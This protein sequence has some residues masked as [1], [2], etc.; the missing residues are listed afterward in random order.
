MR[1]ATA[2]LRRV[3]ARWQSGSA[4]SA[5]D[6]FSDDGDTLIEVLLSIVVLGIAVA[7]L[8]GFATAITSSANTVT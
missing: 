7:L 5:R 4:P 1:R 3:V 8:T 6:R 2:F